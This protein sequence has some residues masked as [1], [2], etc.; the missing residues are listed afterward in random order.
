MDAGH[1]PIPDDR[2][3]ACGIAPEHVIRAEQAC[4]SGGIVLEYRHGRPVS[5]SP[6]SPESRI[7]AAGQAIDSLIANNLDCSPPRYLFSRQLPFESLLIR[8]VLFR[9]IELPTVS[10]F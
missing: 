9:L 3:A 4:F 2:V 6:G 7:G 10:P 1:R 5:D 8:H